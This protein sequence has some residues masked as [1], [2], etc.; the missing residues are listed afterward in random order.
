MNAWLDRLDPRIPREHFA[1]LGDDTASVSAIGA[2][3]AAILARTSETV[4]HTV[5]EAIDVAPRSGP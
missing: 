1:T 3:L 5:S 4:L 2:A